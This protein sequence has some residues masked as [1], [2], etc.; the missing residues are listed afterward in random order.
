VKHLDDATNS[1]IR[2]VLEREPRIRAG[3]LHGSAQSGTMRPDSDVD[4]ALLLGPAE[5]MSARKRLQLA[6]ELS[7]VVG[8]MVDIRRDGPLEC[9][10]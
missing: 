2:K 4:L 8:R 5:Q 1:A 3:F 7:R 6:G 9:G 10:V